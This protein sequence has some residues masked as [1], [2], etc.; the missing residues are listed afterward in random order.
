MFRRKSRPRR[1]LPAR[2]FKRLLQLLLL[3]L[4]I[5][6]IYLYSIWPDWEA[7]RN[8]PLQASRFIQTYRDQLREDETRPALR[9][10]PISIGQ[11]PQHVLRAVVVAEDSRFYTHGGVDLEALRQ[12]MDYNLSR[13]R[14]AYGGST[15]SQQTVK[16]L[17]LTPSRNPLRKWHELILTLAMEHYLPKRRILEYYVNIAE[18][19][20][21][22]YGVDAAAR[23][24]WD[25]P[26]NRI[27]SIEAIELAA[28]LPSPVRNNPR[29]RTRAFERRVD[30]IRRHYYRNN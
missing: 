13:Q 29:L 11:I 22:I 18:F 1:S 3:A 10:R 30:K 5:D 9:W 23:F 25:V 4:A 17:F 7:Y 21:G 8:G 27:G 19:G 28:A 15:I 2:I 14:F 6:A 24:Y 16:N 20:R 12:A 26:V